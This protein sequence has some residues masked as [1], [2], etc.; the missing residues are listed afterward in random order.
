MVRYNFFFVDRMLFLN[1]YSIQTDKPK[2][3]KCRGI[4]MNKNR[5]PLDC[6]D[7]PVFFGF[8]YL[9]AFIDLP[10]TSKRVSYF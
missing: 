1:T 3:G 7:Y 8:D 9:V 6:I 2:S 5:K 4:M 10:N